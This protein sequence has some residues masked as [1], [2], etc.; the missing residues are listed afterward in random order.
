ML[1]DI[2]H[3]YD[4]RLVL[5]KF[6]MGTEEIDVFLADPA[7]DAEVKRKLLADVQ[8]QGYEARESA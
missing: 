2:S 3:P 8:P 1:Y 6:S 7:A 4:L 5:M